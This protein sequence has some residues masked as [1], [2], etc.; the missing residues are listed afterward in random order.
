VNNNTALSPAQ[1]YAGLLDL[2]NVVSLRNNRV[3][4]DVVDAM[5]RAS[6]GTT[7]SPSANLIVPGVFRAAQY[8]FGREGVAYHDTLSSNTGG[9]GSGFQ[10]WNSGW[11]TRND[12]V[13]LG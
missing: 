5:T 11:N 8:D 3:N 1:V 2:T 10:S 7:A 9:M 13:D 6:F 12:G 4:R